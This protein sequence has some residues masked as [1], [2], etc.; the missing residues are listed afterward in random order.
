MC[1]KSSEKAIAERDNIVEIIDL[2]ISDAASESKHIREQFEQQRWQQS[3]KRHCLWYPASTICIVG[4]LAILYNLSVGFPGLM[5]RQLTRTFAQTASRSSSP[6]A[7]VQDSIACLAD[8]AW[9][10]DNAFIA[11]LGNTERCQQDDRAPGL[12]NLYDAHS[13]KLLAQ[14]HPDDVIRHVLNGSLSG[15]PGH[16]LLIPYVHVFWS[17]DGKRLACTF[18]IVKHMVSYGVVLMDRDGAHAQVLLQQQ[19]PSTP[20]YVNWDSDISS[21]GT[22]RNAQRGVLAVY[23]GKNQVK[24]YACSDGHQLA[25]LSLPIR[26]PAPSASEVIL[27][28]SPDGSLLLLSSDAWGPLTIWSPHINLQKGRCGE[29]Y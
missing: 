11:V 14:L 18:I 28:W 19:Q 2:A 7:S 3:L 21:L 13:R 16:E 4:L 8:A 10:P 15:P 6:S 17:P 5:T 22:A 1:S 12:L 26:S 27:R 23:D 29:V 24:L 25:S 9:S 20:F